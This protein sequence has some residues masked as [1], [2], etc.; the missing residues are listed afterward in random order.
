MHHDMFDMYRVKRDQL[1]LGTV[2]AIR[3]E[4]AALQPGKE[5]Y[6]TLYEVDLDQVLSWRVPLLLTCMPNVGM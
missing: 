6:A 1:T 3:V 4:L 5:V 2:L